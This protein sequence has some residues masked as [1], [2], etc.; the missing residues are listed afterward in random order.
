MAR[1]SALQGHKVSLFE[2]TGYLGGQMLMAAAS[3]N[4]G[5]MMPAIDWWVRELTNLNVNIHM[6]TTI[7]KNNNLEYDKIIWA[8]GSYPSQTQVWRLRPHLQSGIPGSEKLIHGREIMLKSIK[9]VGKVLIVD[10]EGG[11]PAVS[12]A[13]TI[14]S[15]AGVKS[16]TVVTTDE[17]FGGPDLEVTFEKKAVNERLIS[18]GVKIFTNTIVD[19]IL[20]DKIQINKGEILGSFDQ[21]VLSTGTIPTHVPENSLAI[22]DCVAPRSI[23]AAVND[24]AKLARTI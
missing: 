13:E 7:D 1:L 17:A 22:G 11:W 18:Q 9:L 20:I 23:W 14:D 3:P 4:R 5:E 2:A 15:M 16:L 6:N 24:A 8:T 10:E 19:K 12:L 21:I